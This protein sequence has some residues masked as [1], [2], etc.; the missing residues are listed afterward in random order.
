MSFSDLKPMSFKIAD[1]DK[2]LLERLAAN[3]GD[4]SMSAILRRL[5]R[6][7]AKRQGLAPAQPAASHAPDLRPSPVALLD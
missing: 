7:E 6:E 4:A 3:G 5:I 2:T 1:D